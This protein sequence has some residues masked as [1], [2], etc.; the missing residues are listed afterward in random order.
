MKKTLLLICCCVLFTMAGAQNMV[1]VTLAGG[2]ISSYPCSEVD[3]INFLSDNNFK[4]SFNNGNAPIPFNGNATQIAFTK[5]KQNSP[6]KVV[7]VGGWYESGFIEWNEYN[8]IKDYNVYCKKAD[9]SAYEKLDDELVRSYS[10]YLRADAMGLSA[11]NYQFKIV[12]IVEGKE[13]TDLSAESDIISVR[14]HDRSGYAHFKYTEGVGAYKDDGTLK[15]G[16][17]VVYVTDVNKDQIVVPGYESAGKGLGWLL[18]NAQYSKSGSNTYSENASDLGIFPIT[19]EHPLVIRFIGKV[20]P[21]E[22]LTV[23]NSTEN[24]G[25][26]GDNGFMARM[27]DAK[28]LTLEGVG[29]DAMI[30]GWGFHFMC[31]DKTGEYG[32]NFEARN[33][34]FEDYP[35][36]ALGMEGVQGTVSSTGV[37][38]NSSS[39]TSDICAPVQR[40]WVHNCNFYQGYCANPAESD[41]AEGDGSCDFKRGR[42]YTLSYCY[43]EYGHKTNLI[44]SSDESLQFDITFHH[45]IWYNCASRI[46]LLRNSNFHFYNNYIF[47]DMT[48]ANAALSYVAS[49]RAN[50]YLYSEFNYYDGC[51]NVCQLAS[52]GVSKSFGNIYYACIE[53][54]QAVIATTRTQ[55]VASNCKFS[56]KGID[57]QNFDTNAALF[58]YDESAQKTDAYITDAVVARQ[59]C[60]MYSGAQKD[61]SN[62]DVSMN[63]NTV[64]ENV[65][66]SGGSYVATIGKA[67]AGIVYAN[68]SSSGKFKGQGI[69]FKIDCSATIELSA[70]SD[71]YG[72]PYLMKADGTMVGQIT[73]SSNAKF[74]LTPG[75]Y[76]IASG[77][78][79][80]ESQIT[81]LKLTR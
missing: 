5:S 40:C 36:D 37:V 74:D 55:A 28:N 10:S 57:Y 69:T 42:F 68:F 20:N 59:E 49:V 80:K 8:G 26:V 72:G 65:D 41:K 66:L 73:A 6:I 70:G 24:G 52:G 38:E 31:S 46:P 23:Y 30:Y 50:S 61:D 13:Q 71:S 51:K 15:E 60:L 48:D 22:G 32:K 62:V 63:V 21:P 29:C 39:A 76:F 4:I 67:D 78:K 44:G 2:T 19:K 53:D 11:G 25:S 1:K 12:P 7:R 14:A 34:S 35:E 18:N 43:F 54:N 58:Y 3:S 33:L 45:N 9:N 47:G 77:S 81:A 27:K 79:S 64:N 16:A 75:V 56:F 17:I